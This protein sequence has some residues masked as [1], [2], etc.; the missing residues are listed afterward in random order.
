MPSTSST[1]SPQPPTTSPPQSTGKSE[2]PPTNFP[3]A[4]LPEGY[5]KVVK[6]ASLPDQVR[7]W[8]QMQGTIQAVQLAPGVWTAL[9]D[10]AAVEDA[11]NAGVLDGF[12]SSIK[13]FERR[14]R[15]GRTYPGACW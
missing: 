11:V 14:Y 4:A 12:C 7:N 3:S 15:S 13:A 5:P 9:Q 10:G 6:V 2:T 8:F 1:D